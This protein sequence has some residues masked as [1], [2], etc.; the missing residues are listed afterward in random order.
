MSNSFGPEDIKEFSALGPAQ[1]LGCS[2]VASLLVFI[3]GGVFLDQYLDTAP[4]LTLI[5]VAIGLF[6]AGY[7]LYE[8]TLIDRK[9]RPAGPI[10]R[11]LE[12]KLEPRRRKQPTDRGDGV[13]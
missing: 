5:G 11:T 2:I 1:G 6:A 13:Q 12:S 4:L 9:D 10:G 3:L 8:L 7:Q